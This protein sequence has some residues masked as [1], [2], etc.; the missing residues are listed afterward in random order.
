MKMGL[1]KP[2]SMGFRQSTQKIGMT[3]SN[4]KFE[5]QAQVNNSMN[6]MKSYGFGAAAK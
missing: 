1:S 5:P 2:P 3:M 4:N 6:Q